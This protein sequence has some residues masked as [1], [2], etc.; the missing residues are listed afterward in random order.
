VTRPTRP[1]AISAGV[2]AAVLVAV[3]VEVLRVDGG[4]A[5]TELASSWQLLDLRVL[6]ANPFAVWYLHTQP[7]LHNL[8]IGVIA[9]SGLPL[10]GTVFALYVASLAV[11]AGLL[12]DLLVRWRVPLVAATIVAALAVADPSLLS[13]IR[14]ASYEVPL[15]TLIVGF[16]WTLDRYLRTPSARWLTAAVGI[17]VALAMTRALFHPAWLAIVLAVVLLARRPPRR[18][19]IAAIAV[20]LLVV[21]GW[22]A[23]NAALVDSASLSSWTGFNLQ[24]GVIG[25][26]SA[27]SVGEAIAAGDVSELALVAPWQRLDVY[28][29]WVGMCEPTRSAPAL[30]DPTKSVGPFEVANFNDECYLPLYRAA[31]D[32]A[33]TMIRREPGQYLADRLVA[34]AISHDYTP[35]G[36]DGAGTS[37]LGEPLPSTSWMD[38]LYSVLMVRLNIDVDASGWTLSIFGDAV[39]LRLVL[40]LVLATSLVLG[41]SIVAAVRCWRGRAKPDRHE[42][43]WL[44]A[45]VT[46]AFVVIGGDL[47]ELGENSRFRSMLD[48]LLFGL[49]AV[50]VTDVVR[51][52]R[53][54]A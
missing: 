2:V 51:R 17:G 13:T 22:T 42:V 7:P 8:V 15:T 10:A 30:A 36:H 18:Q 43:L 54:R 14:I 41:R 50:I 6:E 33:V 12:I 4:V 52:V 27:G 46:V 1:V 34:L 44:V 5:G 28:A 45:G 48:P 19:V 16:V 47:V 11:T 35:L 32:D 49:L 37:N 25:P 31:R 53:H 9:W 40:P 39:P 21:G 3:V 24:R 20:P 26:M 29:Q 23:K 38:R